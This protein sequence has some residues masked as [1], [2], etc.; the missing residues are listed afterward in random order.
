MTKETWDP[1][2]SQRHT[3]DCNSGLQLSVHALL[4][5]VTWLD[6]YA[7]SSLCINAWALPQGWGAGTEKTDNLSLVGITLHI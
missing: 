1:G 3:F 7:L 2:P 4:R 5:D 6:E